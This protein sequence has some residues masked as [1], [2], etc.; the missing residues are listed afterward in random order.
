MKKILLGMVLSLATAFSLMAQTRAITGRVT[1]AEEPEGIP[2]VSVIIKG[3]TLGAIT[4]LDGRFSLQAPSN[5]ETLVFSFVGYMTKEVAVGGLSTFDVTLDADVK[6]LGEVV[7][8]GY[9]TQSKRT[10]TGSIASVSGSQITNAP[11]QSFDQALQGK[12]PGVN[13]ITPN[14]VLNNPPVIRVRGVNSISLSSYPLIVVDGVPTFTGDVSGNSA[15]TNPLASINPGD[16]L[17]VEV[18]KDASAAAIYGSRASNGVILVTTKRGEQGTSKVTLDAWVGMTKPARLFDVLNA[19]QYMEVKNEARA[20]AGQADAFF[21]FLDANGN[22]VDTDWYDV[23]MRNGLGQSYNLGISG[24]SQKT[25]YYFSAGYTSQEGIIKQNSFDRINGRLNID[26][27]V[28]KSIKVGATM[29]YTNTMNSSPNTGSLP[30]QGFGTAGLGRIP[31]MTAPN[32]PVYLNDGS[33]NISS[34]NQVGPGNNTVQAGFYNPQVLLD[35]VSMTSVNNQFMGSVYG[36]VKIIEGLNFRTTYGIDRLTLEDKT[37]LPA[38]HGDGFGSGGSATNLNRTLNRWNWQ[39]TLS[40]NSGLGENVDMSLLLGNEQQ[41]TQDDRWGANRTIIADDFFESYQGNFT[42][43]VPSGNIQTEN[44]LVSFF[45]RANFN[46][47]GKYLVSI[48]GRRDGYSAFA[49]GGKYGNFWGGSVGYILSEESFWRNSSISSTLNYFRLRG[50]YGIVG[51]SGVG[52]FAALGLYNTGLYAVDPTIFY[53][54]PSNPNLTWETSKKTDLGINFGLLGDRLEGELTWYKNLVDGLILAV[55]QAPSKGVPGN[56][57]DTNIG[58]MVNKGIESSI[59][60][61]AINKA[62]FSWDI[63]FNFSTLKNEVLSLE[64]DDSQL[65]TATS[66]LE[67][68]NI[69][70]VGESVGSL[71]VVE[72]RGVNPE[73][74]RRLFVKRGA[75]GQE[76]LV[77]Y[78]HLG[79]G[80]TTLDGQPTSQPTQNA[81]GIIMGPTLPTWFGGFDNTFRYKGFD[82]GIFLQFQGGNYIYNG[83]KAG[84]RDMRFWNNHVD[85]LDRWTPENTD[86]SI[87]RVVYTDNISN[88][89]AFPISENVEKGNFL[90]LRNLSLGYSIPSVL[91]ERLKIQNARVYGQVQN[92]FLI[93]NYSGSDPEISTNGNSSTGS[94]VDRNSI[95]QAKAL[96]FG[97]N[98]TF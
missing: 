25:N 20:N 45:A 86:G 85:V 5:A 29:N 2:G 90:R 44:Y 96:T 74:G 10:V 67:T 7:V 65:I 60:Y 77:Q 43:I 23:V 75:D 95:G 33:Y 21:P 87:P 61:H 35:L 97:V 64:S 13:I 48:N 73:N 54:Q 4:D 92:G 56:S 28:S 93:T 50:S 59:T 12:V 83:S 11:V 46:L 78:D 49:E 98:I 37:F 76:I 9:G 22:Q 39:N 80:W 32:V 70:K 82:L 17:S 31:L 55:G 38:L 36:D 40:Y 47:Y 15:A 26:H 79:T 27:N 58:S 3:S 24:G 84:L 8:V 19:D 81:D 51:N 63:S 57:I 91:A 42:T 30:G 52:N 16:I 69:T 14:G 71:F 94:G 89:S 66:G 1:S 62:D 34:N 6:T 53:S 18:L 72:T 68:V 88:G 41:Y